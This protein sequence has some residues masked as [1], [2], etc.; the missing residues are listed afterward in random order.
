[1]H[2]IAVTLFFATAASAQR[3][4][5]VLSYAGTLGDASG[6]PVADGS[7]MVT[8]R[9]FNAPFA[10]TQLFVE[11]I[12]VATTGG[13][14]T[15][16]LG[17]GSVP[18]DESVFVQPQVWLELQ[19]EADVLSPRLQIA[20]VPFAL[21]S[22]TAGSAGSLSCIGC[23]DSSHI[24]PT[25]VQQRVAGSC[26]LGEA[27][28]GVNVDG[29]VACSPGLLALAGNG[30]AIT[31]ARSDHDH[32]GTYLPLGAATGCAGTDKVAAIDPVSGDVVCAADQTGPTYS[33]GAGIVIAGGTI[34]TSFAGF[35]CGGLDR[36]SGF[37]AAGNPV[38]AAPPPTGGTQLPRANSLVA[39]D[40]GGSGGRSTSLTLSADGLPVI[41]HHD[42][43]GGDLRVVKCGDPACASGNV[44]T[45]VDGAGGTNVGSYSSIALSTDGFPVISYYD[46]TNGDLRV[47]KCADAACASPATLT[48]LDGA[49]TDVGLYTSIAVG[50]D[51]LPVVSYRDVSNLD[52]K[53]AK[54]ADAACAS[55]ATLTT[56]DGAAGNVGEYT[57]IAIGAD[58]LPVISYYDV[59]TTNLKVAKCGDTACASGNVLTT[60]DGGGADL[61]Q[62]SSI[63]VPADG[64]PVIAH[65]NATA[66]RLR[67]VKCAD[68][69]CA[70]S[71][72]VNLDATAN[73]GAHAS[74]SIGADG[75]PVVAYHDVT[76]GVLK[77]AKCGDAACSAGNTLTVVDGAAVTGHF[78]SVAVGGDGLPVIGYRDVTGD[79]LR[80]ARCANAFCLGNWSRR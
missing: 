65:Y 23:I 43:A 34:S 63:T 77:L 79:G 38:C 36:L 75:L 41:S 14:F 11:P 44:S 62:Y 28:V 12:N 22:A 78:T 53:V 29:S 24:D 71:G 50:V 25:Q 32:A 49:A 16:L 48:T 33:E 37:D 3:V 55:P 4:P 21:V 20:S 40:P 26:S 2:R 70:G 54:C 76:N 66:G 58:G 68:P 5:N 59:G 69:A 30:S 1:M 60:A 8:F 27:V 52:L 64:L 74:I 35:S 6:A 13:V 51:G 61:G 31:A 72:A 47:A 39:V 18:L 15:A 80:V 46:Q 45:I 19:V 42:A 56:V 10:G 73:V 7:Y 67:V 57:S 9:L 17:A